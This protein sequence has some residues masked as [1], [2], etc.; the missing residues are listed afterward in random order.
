MKRKQIN[1]AQT[2]HSTKKINN[3][4]SYDKSL[5]NRGN[6][7][8]L[9]DVAILN[10]TP[11]QTGNPG[12]PYEYSDSIIVFLAQLREFMRLPLRQTIGMAKFIF[13]Q[14]GL[15]FKL[16]GR[17]TLSRRFSNLNISNNLD[18][19]IFNSPIVFLPDSTGLKTGGEGE[20][21]IKKHGA[22]KHREWVKVHI[23]IDHAT[24]AIISSSITE[25]H[26]HDS[27]ELSKLLDDIPAEI[28]ER[29]GIDAVIGDGVYGTKDLYA[30]ARDKNFKLV[31]P[32]Q[33]NAIFTRKSPLSM[34]RRDF[35][36]GRV[37]E[38]I[39]ID[40]RRVLAGRIASKTGYE[41]RNKQVIRCYQLGIEAEG[42][43]GMSRE[44]FAIGRQKWKEETGYH[45]RSLV[46]TAMFR[47]KRAFGGELKSRSLINQQ[48]ELKV[49]VSLLNLFTS[50]GLPEY[51]T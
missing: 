29:L 9:L 15:T 42:G 40:E 43:G 3:W 27:K 10:N 46:E 20:W 50:Y 16:P 26:A 6:F 39:A 13:A 49:R 14:A 34:S 36:N 17:S 8:V 31:S 37:D 30:L 51:S 12:H 33:R 4:S 44:N 24:Q 23:G 19:I 25:H 41:D 22:S 47:L 28:T 2:Y 35:E 21:K 7:A 18:K 32:P 11:V 38:K 1:T 48:T 5:E 45:R